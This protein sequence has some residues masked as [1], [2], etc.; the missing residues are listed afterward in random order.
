MKRWRTWTMM[1][2]AVLMLVVCSGCHKNIEY[3]LKERIE[4]ITH[5]EIADVYVTDGS[6]VIDRI[7]VIAS[8]DIEDA[9][10]LAEQICLLKCETTMPPIHT[11]E[12]R[13]I[14]FHY[15]SGGY[16]MITCQSNRFVMGDS[17]EY[18][19]RVFDYNAFL[20]LI[21]DYIYE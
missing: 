21:E 5:A 2:A 20:S 19:C 3:E 6:R 8:L 13:T 14:I 12:G 1:I 9:Q 17:T 10:G 7:E 15:S 4:D 16:E 11:I 18:G